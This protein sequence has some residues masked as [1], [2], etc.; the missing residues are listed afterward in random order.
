MIIKTHKPKSKWKMNLIVIAVAVCLIL[1]GYVFELFFYP[2]HLVCRWRNIFGAT[3]KDPFFECS[4][5][6]SILST[7]GVS[8]LAS[9]YIGHEVIKWRRK[10]LNEYWDIL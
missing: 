2:N 8:L 9:I 6:I 3:T 10:P 7:I 1:F 4:Y 5:A